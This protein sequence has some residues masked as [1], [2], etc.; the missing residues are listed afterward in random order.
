MAGGARLQEQDPPFWVFGQAVG[1]RGAG[2]PGPLNDEV[3]GVGGHFFIP[4]SRVLSPVKM[5]PQEGGGGQEKFGLVKSARGG[6]IAESAA[7]LTG[8]RSPRLA[9]RAPRRDTRRR[10]GMFRNT[11]RGAPAPGGEGI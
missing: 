6:L 10:G 2:R 3:I 8:G 11:T 1:Q 9:D 4:K 7:R 5:S